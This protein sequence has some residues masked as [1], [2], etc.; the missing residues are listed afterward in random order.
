MGG[1]ARAGLAHVHMR[2]GAVNVQNTGVAHHGLGEIGVQIQAHCH[3][4]V[5][6]HQGAQA[7]EKLAFAVLQELSDHGP[8]KIQIHPVHRQRALE[9]DE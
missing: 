3:R 4:H 2:V 9:I 1:S 8:V 5:V 6:A 7:T